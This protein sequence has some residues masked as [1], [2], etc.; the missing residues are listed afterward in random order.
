MRI[1]DAG[2]AIIKSFE[3]C[4]LEAYQDVVGIWTI[5]YGH[6]S[7]A[8]CAGTK[9]SQA[10][11]DFVLR[12]DVEK[13]EACVSDVLDVTV[14]QNQF[15]AM[16]CLAFNIGCKAFANST[17]LRLVNEGNDGAASTQFTRW[18]KAGGKEIAGLTRRR[19]AERKLFLS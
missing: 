14:T 8:I 3:G 11:A 18:N 1:S 12:T 16:V 6:V 4:E 13:F 17:L 15:D 19:E 9:W 7:S 2:I 5:G 10:E